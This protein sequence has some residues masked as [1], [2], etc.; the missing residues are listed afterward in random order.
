[1]LLLYERHGQDRIPGNE[2]CYRL[3]IFFVVGVKEECS[4]FSS[5]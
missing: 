2:N 5:Q 4:Q 1:M 3:I